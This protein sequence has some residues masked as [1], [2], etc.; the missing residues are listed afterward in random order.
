MF[1]TLMNHDNDSDIFQVWFKTFTEDI[2]CIFT[3]D[4]VQEITEQDVTKF[5]KDKD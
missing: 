1:Y 5:L 2:I 3:L 4:N